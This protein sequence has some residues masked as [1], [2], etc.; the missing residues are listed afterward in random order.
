MIGPGDLVLRCCTS[1]FL[2]SKIITSKHSISQSSYNNE[3]FDQPEEALSWLKTFQTLNEKLLPQVTNADSDAQASHAFSLSFLAP[4]LPPPFL[5]SSLPSF[6]PSS[7]LFSVPRF[8]YPLFLMLR[9]LL[10]RWS[11]NP[12]F[13]WSRVTLILW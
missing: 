10:R 4:L 8:F 12:F 13:G 3:R 2:V 9:P 1:L 6:L 5:P 7:L 11:E